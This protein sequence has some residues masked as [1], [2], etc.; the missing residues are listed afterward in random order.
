TL[1]DATNEAIRDWVASVDTTYYL[2]GSAVGPHPYPTIVR[3]FQSVIGRETKGQLERLPDYVIACIGGGSNAIGIF[4]EFLPYPE[5]ELIGVE[6]GGEG[7]HTDRHAASLTLGQ[8]GVLHGA[9]SYLLFDEDGQISPVHSVSAGLD[10]PGVGPQHSHL[11]DTKRAQYLPVT[12]AEALAAFQTLSQVE[13]IIPALESSHAVAYAMQLAPQLSPEKII[14][15]C[16][17]GRGDK[18]VEQVAAML[19]QKNS[20]VGGK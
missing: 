6:A 16:L 13:G 15:V 5:V 10:Y 14:V 20:K 1:K 18:D 17:S 2:I 19:A 7:L 12:D 9:L 4:A 3:D 8:P 11:K